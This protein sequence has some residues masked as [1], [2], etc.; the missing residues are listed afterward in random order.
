MSNNFFL[1][2]CAVYDTVWKNMVER[3]RPQMTVWR[4]RIACWITMA[5]D[6]HSKYV[7]PIAFPLQQWLHERASPLRNIY[8]AFIVYCSPKCNS[9]DV[10]VIRGAVNKFPD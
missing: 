10:L 3:G 2:N 8:I 1:F 4:M 5:T 9:F 7:M 6:T